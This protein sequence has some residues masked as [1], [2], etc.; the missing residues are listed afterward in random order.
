MV[1]AALH[2]PE[3]VVT[4]QT[5][6]NARYKILQ[7]KSNSHI[8]RSDFPGQ[9][10]G[11]R[12]GQG[13]EFIDLRQYNSGDDVRH[14]DWNVT[15][16]SN[17]PYTRLYR[18]EREHI[19]TA[20]VD[21]RPSMFT[22][23]FRL[24]AVS[25][26]LMAASV[27]WQASHAGDRCSAMVISTNG[28]NTTRPAAGYPGVLRAL[29]LIAREYTAGVHW[30]ADNQLDHPLSDTLKQ[31]NQ[32]SRQAGTNFFFSGFDTQQ[33]DTW[34]KLLP[35]TAI[36]GKMKAIMLLD[37][38]EIDGLPTGTYHYQQHSNH[39]SKTTGATEITHAN[40]KLLK[41]IL[42]KTIQQ[43]TRPFEHAGVP[44]LSISTDTSQQ[45][46]LITLHQQRWL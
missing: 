36:A 39:S 6:I 44:L 9:R 34:N 24:R 13:L 37:P 19:T 12:R 40:V 29:E 10:T 45:D 16:R 23:S 32:R 38:L 43:R 21:L 18:E 28:L 30:H 1:T 2:N 22:G 3:T 5:L 33:D 15:A 31:I 8:G 46:L 20:V 26:S 35:A 42:R 14:I 7:Q 41:R 4:L 11:P 27:L 25:A 17:E